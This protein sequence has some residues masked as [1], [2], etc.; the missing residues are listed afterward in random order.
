VIS[1]LRNPQWY[2]VTWY[3]CFKY[4]FR[5]RLRHNILYW[6]WTSIHPVLRS[7]TIDKYL[8]PWKYL[9]ITI[10]VWICWNLSDV[11]NFIN[12]LFVWRLTFT[13]WHLIHIFVHSR[14]IFRIPPAK[15]SVPLSIW[16]LLSFQGVIYCVVDEISVSYKYFWYYRVLFIITYRTSINICWN[17]TFRYPSVI[18]SNISGSS[19]C[20]PASISY[21]TRAVI[22]FE[23]YIW[24]TQTVSYNVQKPCYVI[25][26]ICELR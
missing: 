13:L 18:R 23:F 10:S 21:L 1:I 17:A 4:G 16:L 2:T 20:F 8:Y 7:T 6:C 14:I 3:P 22:A 12:S 26:L 5:D 24:S 15:N 19:R 11:G 25:N 9:R